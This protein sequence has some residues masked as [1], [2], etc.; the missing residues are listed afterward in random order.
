MEIRSSLNYQVES[1]CA[2]KIVRRELWQVR[3]YSVGW[4]AISFLKFW[5]VSMRLRGFNEAGFLAGS[6]AVGK[7]DTNQLYSRQGFQ[8]GVLIA[9]KWSI[10][11][12]AAGVARRLVADSPIAPMRIWLLDRAGAYRSREERSSRGWCTSMSTR[13]HSSIIVASEGHRR[14]IVHGAS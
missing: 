1:T 14:P 10:R 5:E 13:P 8:G 3:R 11:S 12:T 4:L 9:H 6:D 2:C 7:I